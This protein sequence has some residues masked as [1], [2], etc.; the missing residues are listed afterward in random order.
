M[1]QNYDIFCPFKSKLAITYTIS[2]KSKDKYDAVVVDCYH[3]LR[4]RGQNEMSLP[5][6]YI[7]IF[8]ESSTSPWVPFKA[9]FRCL[10]RQFCPS[11]PLAHSL[12]SSES[13]L[14]PYV[15][16]TKISCTGTS[17]CMIYSTMD[18]NCTSPT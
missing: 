12:G 6:K 1:A 11:L 5:K 17:T 7:Y 16:S 13:S 4:L 10:G 2:I 3:S 8:R 15:I 18:E 14:H 9:K